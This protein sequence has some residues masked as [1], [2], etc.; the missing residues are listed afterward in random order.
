MIRQHHRLIAGV[1]DRRIGQHGHDDQ[2]D[3]V[4]Y[5]AVGRAEITGQRE[6]H[7]A[8]FRL[9]A[10]EGDCGLWRWM[11]IVSVRL[12]PQIH[13]HDAAGEADFI[14]SHLRMAVE[15]F[16]PAIQQRRQIDALLQLELV[17]DRAVRFQVGCG[18]G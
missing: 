18:G 12:L 16:Q 14:C 15:R 11:W 2:V 6:Q 13:A 8:H 7:A 4:E 17:A 9:Q 5:L 10:D 1:F 3:S